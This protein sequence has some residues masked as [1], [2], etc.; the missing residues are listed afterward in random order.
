MKTGLKAV[1]VG[2]VAAVAFAAGAGA[3]E[4]AFRVAHVVAPTEPMNIAAEH[5]AKL[6]EERSGGRIEVEVFPAGQL[7]G[8]VEIAEQVRLG[9][10]IIHITDP[11]YLSDFVPDFGVLNGPYLVDDPADFMKVLV[12]DWYRGLVDDMAQ[13][14]RTRVLSMG[15][16]FGNRHIIANKPVR[17]LA[18]LENLAVRVPPNVMWIETFKALGARGTTLDWPEVYSGLANGVVDAAEAPLSSLYGSK[19]YESAKTISLTGHFTAFSGPVMHEDVYRSMPDDL[20]AIV[21]E[22][23]VE[24]G[25]FMTDLVKERTADFRRMLEAEGVTFIEDVDI[26]AMRAATAS[27]YS[28][29]PK[30]SPGVYDTVRAI[31]DN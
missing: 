13:N 9:A 5:F 7:G 8:N 20:R 26:P 24:A 11:G 30:W 29:F 16:F 10:P 3:Q 19:L 25:V 1:L 28:A 23:A 31:L 14:H 2:A 22:A 15:W 12:S 21:D 4:F 18:D 17:T 27:V 6:V